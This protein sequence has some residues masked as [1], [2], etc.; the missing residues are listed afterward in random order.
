VGERNKIK[1]PT[2]GGGWPA[3]EE[4]RSHGRGKKDKSRNSRD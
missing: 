2:Y 3:V 4:K 1:H